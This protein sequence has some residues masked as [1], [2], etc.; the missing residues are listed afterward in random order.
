MIAV[1]ATL[2]N[3]GFFVGTAV[4][5]ILALPCLFFRQSV[6]LRLARFW[7]R[8]SLAWLALTVG[9]RWELRGAENLPQ[10]AALIALK[11]QSA[12]DTIAINVILKNPAMIYKSELGRI[13]LFGRYLAA[14]GMIRIDR[15]SGAAGLR[16][17]I[18]DAKAAA[19]QARP[20]AI[21]PEGT[22]GPVGGHLPYQPGVA[23]LYGARGLPLVPVALNSGLY[24][25]RNAFL[26][27]PG[28]IV[29]EVLPA[30]PPGL[31]RRVVLGLLERKLEAATAALLAEAGWP[32]VDNSVENA[33]GSA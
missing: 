8:C 9:L 4:L 27:R 31:D 24:W 2:Y 33:A 18:S 11:H 3:L 21:F 13:P 28:V 14:A 25:G 17:M 19:A 15:Q 7:T 32:P 10:G 30:I 20:I 16:R 23:G 6:A 1:R 12:W 5:M 26:K 29:V 22:R